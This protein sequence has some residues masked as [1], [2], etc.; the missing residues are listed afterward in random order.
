ML[1]TWTPRRPAAHL[2]P[3]FAPL[4]DAPLAFRFE[5]SALA[6][7]EWS[8][9]AASA[10][11]GAAEFAPL[12]SATPPLTC[13]V[14]V[15][16]AAPA[17]DAVR[18]RVR[19]RAAAS[20][21]WIVALSTADAAAPDL[22]LAEGAAAR[23]EVPALSQMEADATLGARLCS[24]TSVAMVLGYWGRAAAPA[25]LAAEM[26]HPAL[27]IYGVWP[28]AVRAAGARGVAGYLL[29]FPDWR[30]ARWC[31]ERGIPIIASVRYAAGELGGAAVAATSGHLLV[32]VG[33]EGDTVL[34]NDP[35]RASAIA[36]GRRR[37]LQVSEAFLRRRRLA[38]QATP[39][40]V[41]RDVTAAEAE[42]QGERQDQPAERDPERDQHHLLADPEVRERGG[43]GEEDDGPVCDAREQS[44]LRQPRV[45]GR[46]EDRLAEEVGEQ[47]AGDEDE[48]GREDRRQER[49][50]QGGRAVSAGQR[51]G[52]HAGAG[53]EEE[54]RPEG[55][56]AEHARRRALDAGAPQR[57]GH[58]PALHHAVEAERA[59]AAL[60]HDLGDHAQEH[61]EPEE[62]DQH[63]EP[64]QD[65][66]EPFPGLEE[67]GPD[68]V[69]PTVWHGRLPFRA[70][71][72]YNAAQCEPGSRSPC[73]WSRLPSPAAPPR[74][75]G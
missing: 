16:R 1:P 42:G 14:D 73:S 38:P 52:V 24:P 26:F 67:S 29:R 25:A 54:N 68:A 57:R 7:G 20:A 41:G 72:R 39:E 28:A 17:V 50:Q 74:S 22:R 11:I 6:D 35:P 4:T 5:V 27:D 59:R 63:E 46:D 58:A 36:R 44:R 69:A 75:S 31:L 9:W 23:L 30:A 60:E 64:G 51:D 15:F 8:A 61:A 33:L 18:L 21:R 32:L 34:V 55:E 62:N 37:R 53:E 40:Q 2:L 12:P 13:D 10:T 56:E 49:E 65:G 19:V 70:Y 45:D 48:Q 47:P 3:S 43:H 66:R 71:T